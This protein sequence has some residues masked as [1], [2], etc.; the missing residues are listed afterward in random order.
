[1]VN[2]NY[3]ALISKM[4]ASGSSSRSISS[5]ET[6][7]RNVDLLDC[8]GMMQQE[9]R[10]VLERAYDRLLK[11]IEIYRQQGVVTEQQHQTLLDDHGLMETLP[12]S[13]SRSAYL[14]LYT[15]YQRYRSTTPKVDQ[16]TVNNEI[17]HRCVDELG[18]LT[19]S[20]QPCL[21]ELSQ[22][23]NLS[24]SATDDRS[25]NSN[26]CR[27]LKQKTINAKQRYEKAISTLITTDPDISDQESD[28][29]EV[30][31]ER[32]DALYD[33]KYQLTRAG[34][35][36][37]P[38]AAE[39]QPK[40][41]IDQP[42]A[43]RSLP[44]GA[45][46]IIDLSF[47]A[48]RLLY[49][50]E[51]GIKQT[52]S[53]NT[54]LQD[55]SILQYGGGLIQRG[56]EPRDEY[57]QKLREER[58]SIVNLKQSL[59]LWDSKLHS[60]IKLPY[61]DEC[62]LGV[63]LFHT[64]TLLS[65]G[66]VLFAGGICDAERAKSTGRYPSY[67][68]LSLW[69]PVTRD[70]LSAPSLNQD[71]IYHT[72]SLLKDGSVLFVGGE[73]DPGNHP[74]PTEP[75]TNSVERYIDGNME[76]MPSLNLARAKHRA[77]VTANGCVLITGGFDQNS[78][79]INDVEQWCPGEKKWHLMPHLQTARYDHTATL[80]KDGRIIVVAGKGVDER[81][82]N[83]TEIWEA[84]QNRW[85]AGPQ[86][87]LALH[88]HDATRLSDGRILV[89]GGTW[90]SS[91][92]W[93]WIWDTAA[94]Y[95]I[96]GGNVT[97]QVAWNKHNH[98][99][100]IARKNGGALLITAHLILQWEPLA[101]G[102]K[103]TTPVWRSD[104]AAIELSDGRIMMVGQEYG[105][106]ELGR[107]N[108]RIWNPISNRWLY[109]GSPG[110]PYLNDANI[111]E[112]KSGE[113]LYLAKDT[114]KHFYCEI[115]QPSSTHWKNCG[116]IDFEYQ[117][118]W[119][120]E[121][122]FLSDGRVV[123][124][125]NKHEAYVYVQPKDNWKRFQLEWNMQG[126]F[127]GAP[128]RTSKPMT[129]V[130]DS[131]S[132]KRFAINDLGAR[133]LWPRTT[134]AF[135]MLWNEDAGEW[136]YVLAAG[137]MGLD[138][139]FLPGGC[140]ISSSPLAI[141]N[142][143]SSKVTRLADPGLGIQSAP[144]MVVLKNGGVVFAGEPKGAI[145]PGNGFFHA[146]ASCEGIL[147]FPGSTNHFRSLWLD[148]NQPVPQSR[149]KFTSLNEVE[150]NLKQT[151]KKLKTDLTDNKQHQID[152]FFRLAHN[153]KFWLFVTLAVLLAAAFLHFLELPYVPPIPKWLI[154]IPFY[155]LLGIYLA[156]PIWSY[157]A[158]GKRPENLFTSAY[159]FNYQ[160]CQDNP[161]ACLDPETGLLVNRKGESQLPCQMIGEWTLRQK[162]TS[163]RIRFND[164][165][166]YVMTN[167]FS[168][169]GR[170][171]GYNGYWAVQDKYLVWRHSYGS[172]EFDIN[173]IIAENSKR[174]KV[175]EMNGTETFYELVKPKK[176]TACTVSPW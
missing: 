29:K 166:S 85:V 172:N 127:K 59:G 148:K 175:I 74:T 5:V 46:P 51:T 115:W 96:L 77:T 33:F 75:V 22:Q 37:C 133:L 110:K 64:A 118:H 8:K 147:S 125:L 38:I 142:P 134:S 34:W 58:R 169:S 12:K 82:L 30:D 73:A 95:W 83:S 40:P 160:K 116:R 117:T 32:I 137:E 54:M 78:Q 67:S 150:N 107:Q 48:G 57:L 21:P 56:D 158:T 7:G 52:G 17:V 155:A 156:P 131:G 154:R 41:N 168:G 45:G 80:L 6:R 79:P 170:R 66:K 42:A 76:I 93:T 138:T 165:G 126:L 36:G 49:A 151:A 53:T 149:H 70:W 100:L 162:N 112:L 88:R 62:P 35:A 144:K 18:K 99:R 141:F 24:P 27:L 113:V 128:V 2:Q 4:R 174:F 65:D 173:E 140:A 101:T 119:P 69:D 91:T 15:D 159:R 108:A 92:P 90:E 111:I 68:A 19:L 72:A 98:V 61:P 13:D 164:D 87:P 163:Y 16:I 25:F 130:V 10:F 84:G 120:P 28:W 43:T 136:S 135:S 153:Y 89:A 167:S 122:G 105:D 109:A 143:E 23:N 3:D 63:R 81:S 50:G 106:P 124:L 97:T 139:H 31:K 44:A 9:Q 14:R 121:L 157:I 104:P 123:A 145:D 171:S 114:R 176:S 20:D 26:F 146:R 94:D 11:T 132:G 47:A 102:Q 39:D 103:I 1:M 161:E 71:R 152:H 129:E 60:W 86:L 55:G